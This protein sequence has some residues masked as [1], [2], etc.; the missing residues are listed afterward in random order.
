MTTTKPPLRVWR[1]R[2]YGYYDNHP[3]DSFYVS[4][5][6]AKRREPHSVIDEITIQVDDDDNS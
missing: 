6:L 3:Y 4:L 2:S 1:A 5:E